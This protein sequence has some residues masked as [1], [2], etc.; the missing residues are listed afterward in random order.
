MT[1][2]TKYVS[3]RVDLIEYKQFQRIAS[4]LNHEGKIKSGSVSS[5]ARAL[6]IVKINEFIQIEMLQKLANETGQDSG[7]R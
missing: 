3:F 4:I 5:L 7:I 2:E 6:C 1:E